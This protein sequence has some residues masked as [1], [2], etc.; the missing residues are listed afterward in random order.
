V[1]KKY[2]LRR[3]ANGPLVNDIYPDLFPPWAP[4]TALRWDTTGAAEAVLHFRS[5]NAARNVDE[6]RAA[7]QRVVTP[8]TV[9][10]A[11]DVHGAVVQFAGGRL[12]IRR[13]HLGT[14]PAPGWLP[15]YQWQ[16]FAPAEVLPAR[17]GGA[18]DR[19]AH[20]NNLIWPPDRA[21]FP[22]HVDSAP[23]FRRDRIMELLEAR[24]RHD[25]QSFA[26]IQ[27]DVRVLRAK[28]LLPSILQ[29]LAALRTPS[30]QE[31]KALS[32]L[33]AWDLE[34]RAEAPAPALFFMVYRG[35]ALAALEDELPPRARQF[36][37]SQ[38]YGTP[39]VDLWFDD[40]NHPVWD[41]R[42]T[43]ARETRGDV[44]RAA[45]RAAVAELARTQGPDPS[46]WRWGR[47]H[48]LH[49][50]HFFGSR[51]SLASFVNLPQTEMPG[52]IDT[53]WKT[54]FHLGST[55]NPF[56]IVAGP[57]YRMVVDL[58]DPTYGWWVVET[59]TSGWPGSPHY[60]DQFPRWRAGKLVPMVSDWRT[61]PSQSMGV[62]TL[63]PGR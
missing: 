25:P 20:A 51:K 12:P 45:F 7:L 23:S 5:A 32:L 56:R 19:L 35:A 46:S 18:G 48:T 54:H 37:L 10:T 8:A 31:E 38:P 3:S 14:F 44:V 21:P 55:K 53:V 39:M 1:E 62:L 16:G 36:V 34:A 13:H 63:V 11:G 49:L 9:F 59:G 15:E 29:D 26:A 60:G 6:L 50:Q 22:Y 43:P 24:P 2:P 57:V 40:P 30:A 58:A 4:P 61:I 33:R 28:R 41:D 42:R 27:T 47:L 52:G 17:R